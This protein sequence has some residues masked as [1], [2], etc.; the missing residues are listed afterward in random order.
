MCIKSAYKVC[1]KWAS[2]DLM[3]PKCLFKFMQKVCICRLNAYYICW[4]QSVQQVCMMQTVALSRLCADLVQ[5]LQQNPC[6]ARFGAP[7]VPIPWVQMRPNSANLETLPDTARYEK[8]VLTAV[9]ERAPWRRKNES[10]EKKT[11]LNRFG[12]PADPTPCVQMSPNSA[13][14]ETLHKN[15][16]ALR[17][18]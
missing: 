1:T 12:A 14:L 7:A 3:H 6:L 15:L 5:N 11:C 13:I 9:R 2:A 10:R 18:L 4:S 17:L 8:A 16:S